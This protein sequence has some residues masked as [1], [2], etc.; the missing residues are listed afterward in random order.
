MSQDIPVFPSKRTRSKNSSLS[1]PTLIIIKLILNEFSEVETSTNIFQKCFYRELMLH[2]ILAAILVTKDYSL[3][4]R[5][6]WCKIE[7]DYIS[8]Q[9]HRIVVGVEPDTIYKT[10]ESGEHSF[11]SDLTE[12]T[13]RTVF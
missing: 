12:R 1:F 11:N 6:P 7:H 13:R 10:V 8:Y 3:G 5:G 4:F 2:T 9:S